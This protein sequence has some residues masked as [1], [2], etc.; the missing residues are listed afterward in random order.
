MMILTE[1]SLGERDFGDFACSCVRACSSSPILILIL[2][3]DTPL[4]K[5]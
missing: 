5:G 4:A 2:M 1:G 3:V